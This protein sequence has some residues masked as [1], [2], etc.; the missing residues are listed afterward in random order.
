[1]VHSIRGGFLSRT[2]HHDVVIVGGGLVGMTLALALAES[3]WDVALVEARRPPEAPALED[4]YDLRVFAISPASR[5]WLERVGV[6]PELDANRICA[7]RAMHVWTASPVGTLRF[8]ARQ[9]HVPALGHI[10]ENRAIL[11]AAW[12]QS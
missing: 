1:R 2:D 10:V 12:N 8:D 4:E 5:H 3:G 7:Y 9:A 6:W 11:A